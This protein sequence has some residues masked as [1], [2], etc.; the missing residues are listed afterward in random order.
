L[1]DLYDVDRE[2]KN[3]QLK[4]P[5]WTVGD[6]NSPW[7]RLLPSKLNRIR[8]ETASVFFPTVCRHDEIIVLT[9][10]LGLLLH[11]ADSEGV[12]ISLISRHLIS[13]HLKWPRY[14]PGYSTGGNAI[15]SVCLSVR[16]SVRFHHIFRTDWP[17]TLIF[18]VCVGH[19]HGSQ[20][21]KLK[22]TIKVKGQSGRSDLDSRS[23][24]SF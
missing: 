12:F 13:S 24:T 19:Y 9:D 8:A 2:E 11:V 7:Q 4:G 15:A 3:R 1:V 20:E 5:L 10:C 18:C 6:E 22:V 14:R 16:P 23:K 21:L 17:L